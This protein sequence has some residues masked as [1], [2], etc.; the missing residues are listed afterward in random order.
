MANGTWVECVHL[1]DL[2]YACYERLKR[3]GYVDWAATDMFETGAMNR[4]VKKGL[5][6][7]SGGGWRIN[8]E[9][10]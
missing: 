5:A 1:T 2:E 9:P 7:K 4:L 6:V 3:S 8:N 10:E